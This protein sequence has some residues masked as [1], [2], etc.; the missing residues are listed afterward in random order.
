MHK[1]K[2]R[3]FIVCHS[4][5]VITNILA[6]VCSSSDFSVHYMTIIVIYIHTYV[7]VT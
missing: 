7:F 3:K 5:T 1:S 2:K 4:K 6:Y